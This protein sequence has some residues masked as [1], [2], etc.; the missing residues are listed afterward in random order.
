MI[1]I[2]AVGFPWELVFAA[3]PAAALFVTG[4]VLG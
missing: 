3:M 2:A 4:L 1:I